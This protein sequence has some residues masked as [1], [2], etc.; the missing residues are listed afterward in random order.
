QLTVTNVIPTAI[1]NVHTNTP[2]PT[3]VRQSY[4]SNHLF[5]PTHANG[6]AITNEIPTNRTNSTVNNAHND[7]TLA[8][9]TFLTPI[10]RTR[11][12]AMKL[13]TPNNPKQLINIA[14]AVKNTANRNTFSSIWNFL[15]Y[16]SLLNW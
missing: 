3:V 8:P 9:N 5:I 11:C 7:P 14:N 10:S 4:P 6:A 15:E 13:A 16:A 12:S 1:P 2:T